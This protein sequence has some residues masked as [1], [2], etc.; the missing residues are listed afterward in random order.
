MPH[1]PPVPTS[2]SIYKYVEY[3]NS[4]EKRFHGCTF[5]LPADRMF[6]EGF[7]I[8]SMVGSSLIFKGFY[9]KHKENWMRIFTWSI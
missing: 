8:W 5:Y 2:M 6:F 1:V 4:F 3:W 7:L 9:Y